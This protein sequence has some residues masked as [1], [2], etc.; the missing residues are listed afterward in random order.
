MRIHFT[1]VFK[2]TPQKVAINAEFTLREFYYL[3]GPENRV[4]RGPPVQYIHTISIYI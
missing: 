3:V 4:K 2:K 1:R